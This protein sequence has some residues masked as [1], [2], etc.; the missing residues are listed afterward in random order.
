MHYAAKKALGHFIY[1]MSPCN[2]PLSYRSY[3]TDKGKRSNVRLNVRPVFEVGNVVK[4]QYGSAR[5]V[6]EQR[7]QYLKLDY[8]A[9]HVTHWAHCSLYEL[10]AVDI[11]EYE[12][13]N[14]IKELERERDYAIENA[15]AVTQSNLRE[16]S[17]NTV[18]RALVHAHDNGY[19]SETAVALISAGHKLPDVDLSV[20]FNVSMSVH[21]EGN[22]SYYLLRE[23]FGRTKGDLST[24]GNVIDSLGYDAADKLDDII[25]QQLDTSD[26]SINT[27]CVSR[28]NATFRQPVLRTVDTMQANREYESSLSND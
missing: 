21:I 24:V 26:I 4:T 10:V 13:Q 19:C 22:K 15:E 3:I 17:Q 25:R 5:V 20:S 2:G 11:R 8:L 6:V 16:L 7:G 28:A 18:T 23:L 1:Q 14:R 27:L 9:E 12:F